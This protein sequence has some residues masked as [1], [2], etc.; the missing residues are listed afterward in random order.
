LATTLGIVQSH[1]GA[2]RVRTAPGEGAT[3]EVA[4]PLAEVVHDR[5]HGGAQALE[6]EWTGSGSV[7]VIDDDPAVRTVVCQM[8]ELLGLDVTGAA[9]GAQ[10][11][12]LFTDANHQFDLVVLD[13]VM[14]A[15]SGE[16]VLKVVRERAPQMPVILVSGFCTQDLATGDERLVRVQK[17]MTLA[18]LR[19]AVR[20]VLASRDEVELPRARSVAG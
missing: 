8:L 17:P 7:L 5:E 4:F 12:E 9:G 1:R 2:L 20:S 6:S 13:W 14:P 18:E 16:H 19:D 10:G 15:V 11:I 3:F